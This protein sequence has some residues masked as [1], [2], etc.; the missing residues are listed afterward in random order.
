MPASIV[1]YSRCNFGR[2]ITCANQ[3]ADVCLRARYALFNVVDVV[4]RK[5]KYKQVSSVLHGNMQWYHRPVQGSSEAQRTR[6]LSF[7]LGALPNASFSL[8]TYV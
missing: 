3:L 6:L 4:S 2:D 5:V 1:P 7:R 8:V